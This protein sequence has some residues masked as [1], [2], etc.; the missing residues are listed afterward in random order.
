VAGQSVDSSTL[1]PI[2]CRRAR[3]RVAGAPDRRL[4]RS[5]DRIFRRRERARLCENSIVTCTRA[6]AVRFPR[7][8]RGPG[9]LQACAM[10]GI[11]PHAN[12]VRSH[13]RV[14]RGTRGP[15]WE[16]SVD[17]PDTGS[18]VLRVG[19]E[20]LAG[21]RAGPG[22]PSDPAVALLAGQTY[23]RESSRSRRAGARRRRAGRQ[24]SRPRRMLRSLPP[25]A[26]PPAQAPAYQGQRVRR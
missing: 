7:G 9:A 19:G 21:W 22:A 14:K 18:A 3:P 4:G 1:G 26:W 12:R 8:H 6:G 25:S 17:Y 5:A 11:Y 13:P 20:S 16:A 23:R 15:G 10:Q 2:A 24:R